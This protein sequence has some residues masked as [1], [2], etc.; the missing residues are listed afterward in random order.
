ME[1]DYLAGITDQPVPH[2]LFWLGIFF[3]ARAAVIRFRPT[4]AT[5]SPTASQSK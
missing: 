1:Q 2:V 3:I 5:R 4:P